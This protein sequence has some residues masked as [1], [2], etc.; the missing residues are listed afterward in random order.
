M[1]E[2]TTTT[3]TPTPYQ[4][5]ERPQRRGP[6]PYGRRPEVEPGGMRETVVSLNRVTKVVK[7]GKRFS[8]SALIVVGDQKGT[9]GVGLGKANEVQAAIQK[10]SRLAQRNSIKLPIVDGTIPHEVVGHYGAGKVWMKPAGKGTGVI[11]GGGVRAILEAAGVKNILTKSLG[12]S[13]CFSMVYAALEG[14]E[15]LKTQEEILKMRGRA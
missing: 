12:S 6:D 4:R 15:Q 5:P 13:N 9:V 8:F 11:A 3:T 7:G 1:A 14:L 10:G 2:T